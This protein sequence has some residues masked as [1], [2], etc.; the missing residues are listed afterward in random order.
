MAC[1]LCGAPT[2][3]GKAVLAE[4]RT[5]SA[6]TG[7]GITKNPTLNAIIAGTKPRKFYSLRTICRDCKFK[8][9]AERKGKKRGRLALVALLFGIAIM[10]FILSVHK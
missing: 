6:Y 7:Y 4:I 9:D 5:G 10:L 2:P 1:Y 8:L 3:A